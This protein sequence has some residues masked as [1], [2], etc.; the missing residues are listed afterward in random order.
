MGCMDGRRDKFTHSCSSL[1]AGIGIRDTRQGEST[2]SSLP[3]RFS[4][5]SASFRTCCCQT[6]HLKGSVQFAFRHWRE[7]LSHW[8]GLDNFILGLKLFPQLSTEWLFPLAFP[9]I[10]ACNWFPFPQHPVQAIAFISK[11]IEMTFSGKNLW[12]T[13][14]CFTANFVLWFLKT[15]NHQMFRC[16]LFIAL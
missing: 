12:S 13:A 10:S 5:S 3:K 2:P 7:H 16:V 4:V 8:S 6:P 9:V 14:K 15:M 1:Q 11:S